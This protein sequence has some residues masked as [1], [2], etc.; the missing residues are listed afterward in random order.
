MKKMHEV[1]KPGGNF[2]PPSNKVIYYCQ[3]MGIKTAYEGTL[4]WNKI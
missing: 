3:K 4:E 2:P 1:G